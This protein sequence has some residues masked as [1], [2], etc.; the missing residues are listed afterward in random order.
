MRENATFWGIISGRDLHL[1]FLAIKILTSLF[2]AI[3]VPGLLFLL[4]VNLETVGLIIIGVI[5]LILTYFIGST[6]IMTP[7]L[8]KTRS[9]TKDLDNP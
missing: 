6:W 8:L 9:R 7:I 4:E 3:I 5:V 2:T 1:K